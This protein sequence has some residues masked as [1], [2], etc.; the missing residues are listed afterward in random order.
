MP[1]SPPHRA[2]AHLLARAGVGGWPSDPEAL[3]ARDFVGV[4]SRV[5][6][7]GFRGQGLGV[8]RFRGVGLRG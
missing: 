7:L 2:L 3:T 6:G 4:Q 1:F 8:Q 5:Y